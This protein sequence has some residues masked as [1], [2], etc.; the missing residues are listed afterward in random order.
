[1][2]VAA[3]GRVGMVGW[4]KVGGGGVEGGGGT[5]CVGGGDFSWLLRMVRVADLCDAI[6]VCCVGLSFVLLE[7]HLARVGVV[8]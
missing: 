3:I 4:G 2:L 7:N 8:W 6:P 5:G 1:M